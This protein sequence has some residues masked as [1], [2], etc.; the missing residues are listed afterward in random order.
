[1]ITVVSGMNNMKQRITVNVLTV[2]VVIIAFL[3]VLL[4]FFSTSVSF[5]VN[6][7]QMK[8][9]VDENKDA[10]VNG[11]VNVEL[12]SD[13]MGNIYLP[14]NAD[15]SKLF[16]SWNDKNYTLKSPDGTRYESGSAPIGNAGQKITYSVLDSGETII[17]KITFTTYCGSKSVPALFIKVNSSNGKPTMEEV[18]DSKDKSVVGEGSIS[19]E[20][21]NAY[22]TV[23]GRGNSSWTRSKRKSYN[24]KLFADNQQNQKY[25]LKWLENQEKKT[26]KYSLI[27]NGIDRSL[28]RNKVCQN[29][30]CDMGIGMP[31][32]YVDLWVDGTYYGNYLLTPKT[33]YT[34]PPKGYMLELDNYADPDD[35]HFKLKNL[36]VKNNT[37]LITIKE[38]SSDATSAD[39]ETYMNDVW[40]AIRADDGYNKKTGKYYGDYIDMDSWAKLYLML[41]YNKNFDMHGGSNF[42]YRNGMDSSDKL[43]AGPFWD[44]DGSLRYARANTTISVPK[45]LSAAGWYIENLNRPGCDCWF[46]MLGK[47][48]DFRERVQ[49]VYEANKQA[50]DE[51]PMHVDSFKN[52]IRDSAAMTYQKWPLNEDTFKNSNVGLLTKNTVYEKG[53]KYEQKYCKTVI[54]NDYAKNLKEYTRVRSKFFADN[55]PKGIQHVPAYAKLRSTRIKYTGKTIRPSINVVEWDGATVEKRN[56]RVTVPNNY[57]SIGKHKLKVEFLGTYSGERIL[58]YQ[59]VPKN[60][61]INKVKRKKKKA[62]LLWKSDKTYYK[63]SKKKRRHVS[64]YQIQYGTRKSFGKE[65]KTITVKGYK[66]K[67]GNITRLKSGKKYYFR[68]RTYAVRDGKRYYSS[69]SSCRRR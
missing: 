17:N 13:S 44:A 52:E 43:Y 39:I 32:K 38:N 53:T 42:M 6:K 16:L 26:N 36:K 25:K 67:T 19:S 35:P 9:Y 47:H 60:C 29:L 54:W 66:R 5:G 46:K 58:T 48:K 34:A 11:T 41:E 21:V 23:K 40:D 68:I 61:K 55:M 31:M 51:V 20:S 28:M 62:V 49:A 65:A 24:V 22:V 45:Q 14:G 2:R 10:G 7:N 4:C 12:L 59:I 30:A 1:M 56:Y 15:V 8:F 63:I 27:S 3:A 18:N 69:W 37:T 64:G 50:F 33:D 57:G